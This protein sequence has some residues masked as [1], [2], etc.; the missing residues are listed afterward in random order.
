MMK[1]QDLKSAWNQYS[2][3]DASRHR[4][5]ESDLQ[6]MLRRRT[7]SLIERIDR[8]IKI[9]FGA[10]SLL[11]I[12]F[13]L[14][15]FV[16]SPWL[17]E[18]NTIPFWIILTDAF[19]LLLILGTF[20]FF[21]LSYSRAKR[22]YSQSR[23]LKHVLNSIIRILSAYR[24]LFYW[25]IGI[26][27]LVFSIAFVT[28]LMTGVEVAAFRHHIAVDQLDKSQLIRQLTWGVLILILLVIFLFLFFRWAFRK[29]YGHYIARLKETLREL[30]EEEQEFQPQK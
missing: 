18:G 10:L 26:L 7:L 14:D 19:S 4:L 29:L 12:F 15:D 24:F 23:D 30:E 28:G 13:L 22:D 3:T 2:S 9:G 27:L 1:L 11:T 17:S 6:Q 5:R 21:N 25:G 16:L 8:N 20:I